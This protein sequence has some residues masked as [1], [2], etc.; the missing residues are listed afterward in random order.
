[1]RFRVQADLAKVYA[2]NC[3]I[4]SKMG[5][6][7][8]FVPESSFMLLSGDD[9]QT[10]YQFHKKHVHHLFCRTCGVRSFGYGTKDGA[11]TYSVNVRCLDDVGVDADTIPTQWFDGRSL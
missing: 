6:R 2:C 9:A 10:D 8:A 4:C 3:S 7:L 1:V 5:W 11:R